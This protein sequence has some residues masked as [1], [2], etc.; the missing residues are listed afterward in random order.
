MDTPVLTPHFFDLSYF[1][2]LILLAITLCARHFNG[3]PECLIVRVAASLFF[4]NN[5]GRYLTTVTFSR[6]THG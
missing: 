3:D 2:P 4:G 1:I 5:E 6:R